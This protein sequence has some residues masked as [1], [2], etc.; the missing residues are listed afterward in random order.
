MNQRIFKND[1]L[2]IPVD[3]C[4]SNGTVAGFVAGTNG[5]QFVRVCWGNGE[6]IDYL[7]E[8]L[9][10]QVLPAG[11]QPE[12]KRIEGGTRVQ[13]IGTADNGEGSCTEYFRVEAASIDEARS[14]FGAEHDVDGS[15]CGHSHDCCGCWNRQSAVFHNIIPAAIQNGY[16]VEGVWIVEQSLV[17]NI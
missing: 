3:P 4:R 16:I 8:K 2:L 13:S 14:L 9:A 15:R 17:C 6:V 10:S 12:H 1:E 11:E 7:P 5:K